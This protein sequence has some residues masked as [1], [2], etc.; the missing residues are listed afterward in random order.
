MSTG[1]NT[2]IWSLAFDPEGKMLAYAN[3]NRAWWLWD[4][5][6]DRRTSI[7]SAESINSVAYAGDALTLFGATHGGRVL[8]SHLTDHSVKAVIDGVKVGSV[9]TLSVDS[10]EGLVWYAGSELIHV[11]DLKTDAVRELSGHTREVKALVSLPGRRVAAAVGRL[12]KV[13]NLSAPDPTVVVRKATPLQAFAVS[14]DGR[15]LATVGN[16][17]TEITVRDLPSGSDA[18]RTYPGEAV[19]VTFAP[20][21]LSFVTGWKDGQIT[22]HSTVDQKVMWRGQGPDGVV[23]VA[24]SP[25]SEWVA[26]GSDT[27]EADTIRLW[28]FDYRGAG[29]AKPV[30]S[31]EGTGAV[32]FSP[33]SHWLV[34][35]GLRAYGGGKARRALFRMWRMPAPSD[36]QSPVC[37]A[38]PL[39]GEIARGNSTEIPWPES[40]SVSPDCRLIAVATLK[41]V[42]VWNVKAMKAVWTAPLTLSARSVAFSADSRRVAAAMNGG[43]PND[44]PSEVRLWDAETGL[45]LL[46]IL[47]EFTAVLSW[48]A[49]QLVAQT[50]RTELTFFNVRKSQPVSRLSGRCYIN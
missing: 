2:R 47:P 13:W 41:D 7:A 48:N 10:L 27:L 18:R 12:V 24:V 37:T 46:R 28:R 8:A 3:T 33:D 49:A 42:Q 6:S 38:G 31:M 4:F 19:S 34:A 1:S 16:T 5:I 50:A 9:S 40:L 11:R 23:S 44:I 45:Q 14:A 43:S 17:G 29:I 21:G 15:F 20:D 25:D 36:S 22:R 30:C 39:A 26:S 35:N 32:T